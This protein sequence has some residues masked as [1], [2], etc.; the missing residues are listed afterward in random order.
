MTAPEM[1]LDQTG[2]QRDPVA[3]Q[4]PRSKAEVS[5]CLSRDSDVGGCHQPNREYG[6]E[7][8]IVFAGRQRLGS[9]LTRRRKRV[10]SVEVVGQHDW[11]I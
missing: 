2:L 6:V 5:A 4:L 1:M 7:E 11:G 3:A 10:S 9:R 8:A